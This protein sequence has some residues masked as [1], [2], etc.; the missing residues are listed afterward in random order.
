VKLPPLSQEF[1][2]PQAAYLALANGHYDQVTRFA[3][4]E[5]GR[6][7]LGAPHAGSVG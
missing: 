5:L 6:R 2:E 4:V 3:L 7:G 1:D